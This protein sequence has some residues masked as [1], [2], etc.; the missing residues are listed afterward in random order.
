VIRYG[1]HGTC[2]RSL[3]IHRRGIAQSLYLFTPYW[4]IL[5]ILHMSVNIRR[6]SF[7]SRLEG[8]NFH[9]AVGG[10]NFDL[11]LPIAKAKTAPFS[12]GVNDWT[13]GLS[14]IS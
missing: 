3:A 6:I 14:I 9:I 11:R 8:I 7:I 1:Y 5:G 13:T 10:R 12:R 4:I 2:T